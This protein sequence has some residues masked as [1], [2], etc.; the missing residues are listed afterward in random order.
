M[1]NRGNEG[2]TPI[3]GVS[4]GYVSTSTVD[5]HTAAS[6]TRAGKRPEVDSEASSS[7]PETPRTIGQCMDVVDEYKAGRLPKLSAI[8]QIGQV[9]ECYQ[10]K[11]SESD[12]NSYVRLLVRS[13]EEDSI[14]E[15]P[16]VADRTTRRIE[17]PNEEL[18]SLER[19]RDSSSIA[20]SRSTL[21]FSD[22]EPEAK[23]Q[24]PDPSKFAWAVDSAI[25]QSS[26]RPELGHTLSL[27]KQY[28]IDIK[29]AKSNLVNSSGAPEFP[30]AEWT[31]ILSGKPVNL[32]HVFS[33]H[34]SAG[35]EEKQVEKLGG[36]EISY[37]P[38]APSKRVETFSDWVY[39]WNR[40]VSAIAYAFP[41]RSSELRAY[42]D[43]IL[44]IF[45]ALA[46]PLHYRVL[47]LDKAIRSRVASRRDLLLT[48][49]SSFIDL[50]MQYIHTAGAN[51][52]QNSSERSASS[53]Q[54][55]AIQQ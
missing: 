30:D 9:L 16:T 55:K 50:Q 31:N 21:S 53:A 27:L 2:P 49:Y 3:I 8:V 13:T 51:V 42:A 7:V 45:G 29:F 33:G 19:T 48:D 10:D 4:Q 28:A 47:E 20:S 23:R 24:W 35:Q 43:H 26:L 37:R 15:D 41:N 18:R 44:G 12:L 14:R 34:Y 22:D 46:T 1:D 52:Y 5:P 11:P 17:L 40:T 54:F 25:K 38:T 6:S 32:D 36:L 39:A